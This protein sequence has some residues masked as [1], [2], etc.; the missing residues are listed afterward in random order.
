MLRA[1]P[2]QPRRDDLAAV[3]HAAADAL[4][5]LVINPV[6]LLGAKPAGLLDKHASDNRHRSPQS[7][8]PQNHQFPNPTFQIST[9]NHAPSSKHM[10]VGLVI[11]M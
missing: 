11:G 8:G 7:T 4:Q 10:S 5:I 9:N 1:G 3:G 2:G 6:D